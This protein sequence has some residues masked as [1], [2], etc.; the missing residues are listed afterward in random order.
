MRKDLQQIYYKQTDDSM[1]HSIKQIRRKCELE[2]KDD[3]IH[4][5]RGKQERNKM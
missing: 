2:R 5:L 4:K 3:G 1:N